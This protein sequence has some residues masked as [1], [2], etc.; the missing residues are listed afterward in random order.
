MD[1]ASTSSSKGI[2]LEV[3]PDVRTHGSHVA[4]LIYIVSVNMELETASGKHFTRAK[5][6]NIDL[7]DLQFRLEK[8]PGL[9]CDSKIVGDLA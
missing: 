3:L 2:H 4:F 7:L 6:K 1:E 9:V 5:E 8:F